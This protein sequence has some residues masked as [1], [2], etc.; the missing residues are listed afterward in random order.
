MNFQTVTELET[1]FI[2]FWRR[3]TEMSVAYSLPNVTFGQAQAAWIALPKEEKLAYA[4]RDM[5]AFKRAA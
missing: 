5:L 4:Y 2:R 1:A 3:E